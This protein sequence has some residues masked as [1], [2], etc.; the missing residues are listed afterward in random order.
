MCGCGC[1]EGGG[2]GGGSVG[3]GGCFDNCKFGKVGSCCWLPLASWPT[4]LEAEGSV[5]RRAR[6]TGIPPA[7]LGWF[8]QHPRPALP[9]PALVQVGS[10]SAQGAGGP[11]MRDT[12]KRVAGVLAGGQEG[13]VE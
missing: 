5:W 12:I 11:V 9:C 10:K 2:L 3:C 6:H 8:G 4:P 13:A 7:S 1:V